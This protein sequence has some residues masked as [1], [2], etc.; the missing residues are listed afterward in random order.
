MVFWLRCTISVYIVLASFYY[1]FANL[2]VMA[3]RAVEINLGGVSMTC[4]LV[5]EHEHEVRELIVEVLRDEGFHIIEAHSADAAMKL[6]ELSSLRLIVTAISLPGPCDGIAL[7]MAARRAC[8]GIPVIFISGQPWKLVEAS[9]A[10]HDA[11]AFL[12]KPFYFRALLND[13]ERL[14]G[15]EWVPPTPS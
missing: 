5:V 13:I 6:L 11:T 2:E 7:A 3:R 8:P 9:R 10:L 14:S 4:I 15:A 1:N 12:Q